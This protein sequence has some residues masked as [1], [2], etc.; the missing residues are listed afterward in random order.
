[1]TDNPIFGGNW[2]DDKLMR[3]EKYLRGLLTRQTIPPGRWSERLTALFGTDEWKAVFYATSPQLSMFDEPQLV[4][5]AT[6][7]SIQRFFV[8]RLESIF[9]KVAEPRPLLNSRNVPLYLL[10]F[11]ASN[12][13]GAP[14]AVNIAQHILQS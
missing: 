12:A 2:T 8:K 13:R 1:M 11:A 14:I 5:T 3:L 6:F 9:P 7:Q 10:C 4:K